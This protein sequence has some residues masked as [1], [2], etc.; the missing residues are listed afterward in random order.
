MLGLHLAIGDGCGGLII[1][2]GVEPRPFT[3]HDGFER[4]VPVEGT[5]RVTGPSSV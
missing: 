5:S 1:V 4:A 3:D 2:D